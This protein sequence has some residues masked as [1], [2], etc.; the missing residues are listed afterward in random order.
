MQ[1]I[2]VSVKKNDLIPYILGEIGYESFIEDGE[3]LLA[4]IQKKDFDEDKLK[5]CLDEYGLGA[6]CFW[7]QAEDKDWNEEWE[8]EN[9]RPFEFEDLRILIEA[10]MAFGTGQHETTRMMVG[11]LKK[12]LQQTQ[13]G[14]KKKVLDA[15]CGTGILS[16]AASM[17]GASEVWGYDIDEWSVENSKHNADL[18][19]ITNCRF[20]L[21]DA[22]VLGREICGEFDVVMANIHLNIL[23]HDISQFLRMMHKGSMLIVSGFYESDS[24]KL[25]D[26]YKE[27][28]LELVDKTVSADNWCCLAFQN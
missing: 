10:K 5:K 7:K 16:I 19:G 2:E 3:K 9:T 22:S 8:R 21:G 23:L 20:C 26:A 4:Y 12:A 28:G 24:Y 15:G 14:S 1:Y 18:N 25:I 11:Q 17:S 27:V 13:T 6:D